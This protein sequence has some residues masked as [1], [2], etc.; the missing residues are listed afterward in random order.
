MPDFTRSTV[1]IAAPADLLF[2][3][4]SDFP[5]YP[6]WAKE[7]VNVEV[8]DEAIPPKTVLLTISASWLKDDYELLY[9]WAADRRSVSWTLGKSQLQK[10]QYGSYLFRQ[11]GDKTEVEYAISLQLRVPLIGVLRRKI[12]QK[13]TQTCLEALQKRAEFLLNESKENLS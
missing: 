11:N 4:I 6:L 5:R 1:V 8:L 2:D 13:I 3:I 10:A 9:E 12:E 7:I